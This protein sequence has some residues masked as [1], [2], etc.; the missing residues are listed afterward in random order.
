MFRTAFWSMIVPLTT[1][2]LLGSEAKESTSMFP[3][4]SGLP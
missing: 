4:W 1:E 2:F 3:F